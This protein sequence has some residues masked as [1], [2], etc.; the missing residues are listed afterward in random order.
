MKSYTDIEQSH[1][2]AEILPIESADM[3]YWKSPTTGFVPERP[4]FHKSEHL[5]NIPAWSLSALLALMPKQ[6][7]RYTKSLYWFDDAWHCE[8]IDEDSEAMNDGASAD[9]PVDACVKMI[10]KLKEKNLL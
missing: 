8:Y 5:L 3:W 4:M 2:L 6:F 7:G 1:K 10:L 9:N